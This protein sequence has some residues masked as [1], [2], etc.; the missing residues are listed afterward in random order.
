MYFG[1]KGCGKSTTATKLCW[2]HIKKGWKVY[3]NFDIPYARKINVDDIGVFQFPENSLLLIDEAGLCFDSRDFKNFKK[4]WLY[5]FKM[6][7]HYK[8]KVIL[9]SQTFDVDKKLR[10]LCDYMYLSVNKFGFL[11]YSKRIYKTIKIIEA[12]EMS[13]SRIAD[14]LKVESLFWFWC[15]SR[16]ITFLPKWVKHFNSF[17]CEEFDAIPYDLNCNVDDK[18]VKKYRLTDNL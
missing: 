4:S 17:D 10:D 6:Q 11:T 9:W 2:Q 1:K 14:S 15:G 7:R 13:E 3:S 8:V 18:F 5:F 16:Q 12:N